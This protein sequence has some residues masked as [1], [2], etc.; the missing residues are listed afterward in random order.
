M[1]PAR[2]QSDE[3]MRYLSRSIAPQPDPAHSGTVAFTQLSG[4]EK[5]VG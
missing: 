4:F 1:E 3:A 2:G 5:M